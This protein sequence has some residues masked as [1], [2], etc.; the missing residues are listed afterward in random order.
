MNQLTGADLLVI[1]DTLGKS[2]SIRDNGTIFSYSEDSRKSV[3]HKVLII[4]ESITVNVKVE[5]QNG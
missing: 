3:L 1:L 2:T 5:E 4:L